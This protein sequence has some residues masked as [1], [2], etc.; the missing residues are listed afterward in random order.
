MLMRTAMPTPI[1]IHSKPL[2]EG[3]S[4]NQNPVM[5]ICDIMPKEYR[6]AF[7]GLMN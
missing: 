6:G 1:I 7:R 4:N 3:I 5:G 2:N